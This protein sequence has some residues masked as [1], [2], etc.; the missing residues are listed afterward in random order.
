M[1]TE[2]ETCSPPSLFFSLFLVIVP[3]HVPLSLERAF[4]PPPFFSHGVER[5]EIEAP[6]FLAFSSK[7]YEGAFL[8]LPPL[9]LTFLCFD[10][11]R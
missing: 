2:K 11:K 4:L 6:L 3:D 1:W 7:G 9:L 8:L 10:G 5:R